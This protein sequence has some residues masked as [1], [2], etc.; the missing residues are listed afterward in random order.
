MGSSSEQ[1]QENK[2][3]VR[4]FFELLDLHD[5]ES[6]GQLLVS[7]ANY[8]FHIGG[9]PSPVDWNE[10]KRLLTGVNNAFPDLRHEITDLIAEGDKVAIRLSVTGTHK[11]DFQGIPPSGKKL[12]LHEMGFITIIGGKITE[13]WISTDTMRLMQQLGAL[14]SPSPAT[15]SSTAGS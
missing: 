2:Q 5:T 12:S 7:S 3:L 14:P 13:G 9:M 10:H 8:S 4:Q 11:G 6:M 15:S 1:E